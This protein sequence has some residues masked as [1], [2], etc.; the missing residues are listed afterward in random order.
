MRDDGL[1][2]V[3][4]NRSSSLNVFSPP[5]WLEDRL[6]P[7]TGWRNVDNPSLRGVQFDDD[8]FNSVTLLLY[9]YVFRLKQGFRVS[10]VCL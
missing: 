4:T 5:R 6:T 10:E 7:V 1:R 8:R 9:S 2:V 3:W